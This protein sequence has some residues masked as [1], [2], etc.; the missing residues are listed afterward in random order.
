MLAKA[1]SFATHALLSWPHGK[2]KTVSSA[3]QYESLQCRRKYYP[4]SSA[5]N[6][7]MLVTWRP[8]PALSAKATNL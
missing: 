8:Y 1:T 7:Q 3:Q 4:S 5:K 2:I 6:L